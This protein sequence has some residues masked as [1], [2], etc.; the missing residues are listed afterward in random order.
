ME[1]TIEYGVRSLDAAGF[2]T[3]AACCRR[4]PAEGWAD[5]ATGEQVGAV[6]AVRLGLARPVDRAEAR[7]AWCEECEAAL[8][9]ERGI[10]SAVAAAKVAGCENVGEWNSGGGIVVVTAD[11]PDGWSVCIGNGKYGGGFEGDDWEPADGYGFGISDAVEDLVGDVEA[12]IG[13][14]TEDD[15]RAALVAAL[16]VVVKAHAVAV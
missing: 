1:Q 10:D 3:C 5:P 15:A 16:A 4:T 12:G 9:K 2:V 13:A 11:L 6:D 7:R 14:A 8:A